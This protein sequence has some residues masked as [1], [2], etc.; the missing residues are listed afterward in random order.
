M[1]IGHN[2][3]DL[4]TRIKN[5][6]LAKRKE[7]I[8]PFSNM[9]K[10][11]VDLLAKEGFI[12]GVEVQN[13]KGFKEIKVGLKFYK[14]VPVINDVRIISKPSR[15]VYKDKKGIMG[16]ERRGRHMVFVSTSGGIMTGAEAR[17]K[18]IGGEILFEIW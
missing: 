14:R 13:K 11:I 7:T 3:S 8:I 4:I 15:R 18:G 16:I 12:K 2:V 17:K 10:K 9:N 6:S 1:N 5:A